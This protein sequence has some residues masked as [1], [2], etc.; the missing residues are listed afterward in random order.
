MRAVVF[1][2][3]NSISLEQVDDP[4]CGTDEV[5]VEVTQVGICGTDLH[6]YRDEYLTDFPLIAGHEFAGKI[7]EV[8]ENVTQLQCGERVAVDPNLSCDQ[9]YF[10]RQQQAN[11]CLNWQG[12]GITRQGGFAEYVAVPARACY[13][14]PDLLTDAQGAFVEPLSCVI[15]ALNRLRVWP[16]DEVLIFGAGP[17]GLL[18]V[19][20]L[21]HSGASQIVVVEKEAD[22]RTLAQE[23]G[24]TAV[25][26]SKPVQ[27]ESLWQLAPHG[28]AVVIDAT[29]VPAVIEGALRFLKPRGQYLQFGVAPE[30]VTIQ[31]SPYEIFRKDW[32]IIGSFALCYTF[33][34]AIAWLVNRVVDITPLISH[35]LPLA[36]FKRGFQ[37][38]ADGQTLKVHLRPKA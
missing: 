19:Q 12:I 7:V 14:I 1:P 34:P 32:T 38:F 30:G 4:P 28:F 13:P 3:P 35:T 21:H 2:A 23:M 18:L 29:G 10:C 24:A 27:L 5:I 17:M 33:Q 16:G 25:L 20:A 11:H 15:H 9:C 8:G 36:E 37:D 22:R 6:I 26:D 31:W